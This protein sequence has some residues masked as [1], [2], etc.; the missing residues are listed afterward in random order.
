[1][2]TFELLESRVKDKRSIMRSAL[3]VKSQETLRTMVFG[4]DVDQVPKS[5]ES[6]VSVKSCQEHRTTKIS[7]CSQQ[8]C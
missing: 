3:E 7:C 2:S 4:A 5:E 8:C 6:A 1:M